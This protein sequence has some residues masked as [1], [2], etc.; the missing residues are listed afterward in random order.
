MRVRTWICSIL[1]VEAEADKNS[2]PPGGDRLPILA[3]LP[4]QL[5]QARFC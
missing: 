4:L 2:P 1:R 5:L 3:A